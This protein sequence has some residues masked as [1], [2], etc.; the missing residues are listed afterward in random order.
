MM[1]D[2][3]VLHVA[4]LLYSRLRTVGLVARRCCQ[5]ARKGE[6]LG[7]V[8]R[9]L[10]FARQTLVYRVV[11]SCPAIT[12]SGHKHPIGVL[13]LK[14]CLTLPIEPKVW[15]TLARDWRR[16]RVGKPF[17]KRRL[18]R[19]LADVQDVEI[20]AELQPDLRSRRSTVCEAQ[21]AAARQPAP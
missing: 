21:C 5:A 10:R 3:L 18:I 13:G 17:G 12:N 8:D 7:N 1:F 11:A 4:E 2:F 9:A 14:L 16:Q 20:A 6:I 15:G 19:L